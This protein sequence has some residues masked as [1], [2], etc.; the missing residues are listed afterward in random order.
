[1]KKSQILNWR[2]VMYMRWLQSEVIAMAKVYADLIRKGI[3]TIEDV[4]E[5]LREEVRELLA[6]SA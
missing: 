1:M 4:P 3:K 2:C 6:E 5:K